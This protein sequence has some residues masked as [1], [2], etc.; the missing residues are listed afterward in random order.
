[1]FLTFVGT[2]P[3]EVKFFGDLNDSQATVIV[4]KLGQS[5]EKLLRRELESGPNDSILSTKEL[6]KQSKSYPIRKYTDLLADGDREQ[7]IKT[8]REVLPTSKGVL[9]E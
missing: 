6:M 3:R 9:G 7:A 5:A 4:T 8:L 2:G 1:M